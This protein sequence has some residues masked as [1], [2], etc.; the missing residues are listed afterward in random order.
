MKFPKAFGVFFSAFVLSFSASTG[1]T[2]EGGDLI[3]MPAPEWSAEEWFNSGILSPQDLKGRVVLVRWWTGP[4][5]PYC[6]RSAPVLNRLYRDFHEQ[7]LEVIGFY[8]HKSD[9]PLEVTR[10]RNLIERYRFKFPVAIDRDWT[11]LKRWW[12]GRHP[13]SWTS[14]TFLIDK[15]GTIRDV[16][17]GGT[18]SRAEAERLRRH[19]LELLS[20]CDD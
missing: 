11:N 13:R 17:P 6:R 19:I 9:F 1:Q 3:G 20:C 8:H 4:E 16:H 14:V 10:V 2:R 15:K 5:C 12:L 7:G 18:Y